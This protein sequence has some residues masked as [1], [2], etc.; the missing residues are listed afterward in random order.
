[1]KVCLKSL[2][3]VGLFLFAAQAEANPCVGNR[4]TFGKV[5]MPGKPGAVRGDCGS[6]MSMRCP[7]NK[8]K[9]KP[10]PRSEKETV[11]SCEDEAMRCPCNKPKPKP[12]APVAKMMDKGC[13]EM[14]MRGC[15]CNKPKPTPRTEQATG[16]F[17]SASVA[18]Q[19]KQLSS[20]VA[21][22]MSNPCEENSMIL[23]SCAQM[24]CDRVN[25]QMMNKM[26]QELMSST[27]KKA[28]QMKIMRTLEV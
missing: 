2:T 27:N 12:K 18:D 19:R 26:V 3:V 14:G 9:P 11:K 20:Q 16:S 6:G 23:K 22:Y 25:N 5:S 13:T 4:Q 21:A 7:C 1:M 15:P 10:A 8:P 24:Y 28:V 17:K